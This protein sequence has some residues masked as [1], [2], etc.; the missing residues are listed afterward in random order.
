MDD[1]LLTLT[2]RVPQ[3]HGMLLAGGQ[4]V[5]QEDSCQGGMDIHFAPVHRADGREEFGICG[6]FDHIA[7]RTGRQHLAQVRFVIV[8]GQDEDTRLRTMFAKL[9]HGGHTSRPGHGQVEQDHVGLQLGTQR[10]GLHPIPGL[11][12]HLHLRV[13]LQKE[14]QAGTQ[15]RMIVG[16]KNPNSRSHVSRSPRI[17]DSVEGNSVAGTSAITVVPRP[18]VDSMESFPPRSSARSRIPKMPSLR[19]FGA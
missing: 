14:A 15:D 9:G 18:G 2:E 1:L 13:G 16:N 6:T 8:H 7:R 12:D 10:D 19:S 3:I 11:S 5:V 4:H 17:A